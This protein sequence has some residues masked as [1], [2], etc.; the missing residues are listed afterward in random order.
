M[1]SRE[2]RNA[3]IDFLVIE[4]NPDDAFLLLHFLGKSF[5]ESRRFHAFGRKDL[6][7]YLDEGNRPDIILSDWSLPQFNGLAALEIVRSRGVDAPFLIVSGKI[8][9]EAA[10]AAIRQGVFDY[11]L[12]DNLARLPTAIGHALD[13]Y[14]NEKKTRLNNATLALQA[15]ALRAA[16]DAI[17]IFTPAGRIEQA[18]PAFEE[19]TDYA[20]GELQDVDIRALCIE[21]PAIPPESPDDDREAPR[22]WIVCGLA[23]T[24]H[25]RQYFEEEK[26]CPV[27]GPTGALAHI[28]VIKKDISADEQRKRELEQD[29]WLSTAIGQT[30]SPGALCQSV[31]GFLRERH[32]DCRCGIRLAPTVEEQEALW[33]GEPWDMEEQGQAEQSGCREGWR[34]LSRDFALGQE[35]IGSIRIEYPEASPIDRGKLFDTLA[36]QL[37]AAIQRM[38]AQRK[39]A[40]QVRNISFLQLI[41]R[42]I[43]GDM[44]FEAF[45]APLLRQIQKFLDVDAVSLF[46][47]DK[48]SATM[49]C[50][51]QSGFRTGRIDGSVVSYGDS[52]VGKAAVQQR[53]ISVPALDA[54]A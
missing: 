21:V 23:K 2:R 39:V 3:P 16:P 30:Q 17:A 45:A 53:I 47:S 9:E 29:L 50:R 8:G 15:T 31:V 6:E 27:Y 49:T 12:K 1:I 42:T 36:R 46:L 40:A 19:L 18:N 26:F 5:P 20:S 35:S 10:T 38:G 44:D 52:Y 7:G 51:A 22:E 11:V 4:D 34:L 43:S 14:E 25:N 48:D 13:Q 32:P 41:G 28:V 24:R 54:A 33:F 37:E